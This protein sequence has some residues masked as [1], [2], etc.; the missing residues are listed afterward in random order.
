MA[1]PLRRPQPEPV[2]KPLRVLM[3]GPALEVRGGIS[4]VERAII[5][6]LP[7][8]VT[9]THVATMREGS[10]AAKL[11]A[12]MRSLRATWRNTRHKTRPDIVHI[13][14]ASR[15]SSVRKMALAR[16]ALARGCNVVMHAHG[17]AYPEYWETL[18]SA[19]K[20]SNLR[21]LKKAS[22]L[23]V[24]GQTWRKFFAGIGVPEERIVVLPNP[25]QLPLAVP[26]RLANAPVTFVCL[27]LVAQTKGTFDL[28]EAVARLTP[29]V[30]ARLRVII[31]G[32][33]DHP[34]L[35]AR[36]ARHE[37]EDCI[38]TREWVDAAERDA[39]LASA[40]AFVLPSHHEG[41]PMALL[42]AMA[43]GLPAICTPVGAIP[44]VVEHEANGLLAGARDIAALARAIERLALDPELR[45][46]LGEAA[47]R[48]I[49][50]LAVEHT[51]RRLSQLYEAVACKKSPSS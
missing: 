6:A 28:V 34:N 40:H 25:V 5:D 30:R 13:H 46:R 41:M 35:L 37:L 36:I 50:P 33:G 8:H 51:A 39:L 9:V 31:A 26:A 32:N 10:K 7:E 11:V 2:A 49:E 45:L 38:E 16:L 4:A 3:L 23:I 29:E 19:R 42:E 48:R 18:S 1:L 15:A 21:V 12:F 17:G 47:R 27:G 14:F 20:R 44:E 24:L 22:A 43:W